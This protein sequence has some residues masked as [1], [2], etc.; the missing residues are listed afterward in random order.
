MN[1]Q[2][3]ISKIIMSLICLSSLASNVV[4]ADEAPLPQTLTK[5]SIPKDTKQHKGFENWYNWYMGYEHKL[6]WYVGV[7]AGFTLAKVNGN[8][9]TVEGFEEHAYTNKINNTANFSLSGGLD[10]QRAARSVAPWLN[11][12]RLGLRYQNQPAQK[13]T[14]HAAWH[15][16]PLTDDMYDYTYNVQTQ[17]LLLESAISI[18]SWK[19]IAPYLHLGFGVAQIQ[20]GNYQQTAGSDSPGTTVPYAFSNHTRYSGVGVYGLGIS[21]NFNSR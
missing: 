18:Y 2:N 1:V 3:T 13:L 20:A 6:S 21:F 7:G 10:Y 4:L 15:D 8:T 12:I 11:S 5:D 17:M 14:G 9:L 19:S 16:D